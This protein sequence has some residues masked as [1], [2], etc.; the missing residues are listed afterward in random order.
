MNR[1]SGNRADPPSPP[2]VG[3]SGDLPRHGL[4]L[5]EA[6]PRNH[7]NAEPEAKGARAPCGAQERLVAACR[8]AEPGAV[9]ATDRRRFRIIDRGCKPRQDKLT[10]RERAAMAPK[11][12]RRRDAKFCGEL[13][14][15]FFIQ[16]P[17]AHDRRALH[18]AC[19]QRGCG[20]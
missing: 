14:N 4:P 17:I 1:V 5:V 20:G 8:A 6:M 16:R 15:V 18:L 7:L 3:K 9:D 11:R 10:T 2:S 13:K 19:R 12:I